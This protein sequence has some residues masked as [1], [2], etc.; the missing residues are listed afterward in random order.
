VIS[1]D[2]KVWLVPKEPNVI[3]VEVLSAR[4]GGLPISSR[5]ILNQLSEYAQNQ[6]FKVTLYRHDSHP[7]AIIELQ[8]SQSPH[9]LT[10]LRVESEKIAMQ[11]KTLEHALGPIVIKSP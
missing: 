9:I 6:N 8:Q 2:L 4:A 11:G 10:S 3:A 7:V 1:Y 5:A